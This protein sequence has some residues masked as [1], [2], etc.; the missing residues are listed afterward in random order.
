MESMSKM[1]DVKSEECEIKDCLKG[2]L[3]VARDLFRIRIH[4]NDMRVNQRNNTANKKAGY[5]CVGCQAEEE[6]NQHVRV[7]P[8][9]TDLRAGKDL[10]LSTDLVKYFREVMAK[11][12]E[13]SD[14]L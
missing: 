6:N 1:R 4:M 5:V 8:S 9:Y 3:A 7:C 2:S 12:M 13:I 14:L 10:N 11:R